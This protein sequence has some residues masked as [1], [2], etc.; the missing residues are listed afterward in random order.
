MK[1]STSG[2]ASLAGVLAP[3]AKVAKPV[4]TGRPVA[5]VSALGSA[6]VHIPE[7]AAML[8]YLE[9]LM[10]PTASE[11]AVSKSMSH[12]RSVTDELEKMGETY[13]GL[14]ALLTT[15]TRF[16]HLIAGAG[17]A[18]KGLAGAA[19]GYVT[20]LTPVHFSTSEK[21]GN[22]LDKA[23]SV[24]GVSR[25]REKVLET[26][27]K[28]VFEFRLTP[29]DDGQRYFLAPNKDK[30]V[31]PV[32]DL[33]DSVEPTEIQRVRLDSAFSQLRTGGNVVASVAKTAVEALAKNPAAG[34]VADLV[35]KNML[36]IP[37]GAIKD[38]AK[39][40][41][42]SK[43]GQHGLLYL[44]G[45]TDWKDRYN[46]AKNA[47]LMSIGSS[48]IKNTLM[49]PLDT[50]RRLPDGA[51]RILGAKNIAETV[52]DVGVGSGS[53]AARAAF[54][55]HL[56]QVGLGRNSSDGIA[57]L[58]TTLTSGALGDAGEPAVGAI[59][60]H[61]SEGF[62]KRVDGEGSKQGAITDVADKV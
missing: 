7:S 33:L 2:G 23:A 10:P 59:A 15:L 47:T 58:V 27:G 57:Q 40:Y 51:K 11:E 43:A 62:W 29:S 12:F 60:E 28:E 13:E 5:N 30:L 26:I 19:G 3:L 22:A 42:A 56:E 21:F 61:A 1:P 4:V 46:E 17:G 49:L 37:A 52:W 24:A 44:L 32:A 55:D 50:M 38:V 6:A 39:Y 36:R 31:K 18:M 34:A 35:T 41:L 45:R 14:R 9:S 54:K 8:S 48:G 20:D 25:A 53:A 16:D